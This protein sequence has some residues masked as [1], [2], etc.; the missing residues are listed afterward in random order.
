[1][2][3]P[4]Y[5]EDPSK[6]HVGCEIPRAYYVPYESCEAACRPREE[7]SR[8]RM[9]TGNWAFRFF[10]CFAGFSEKLLEEE[11]DLSDWDN[12]P[13]PSCWQLHGYDRAQYV[14]VNYP[15]PCDP[16][17]VPADNP[18]GLYIRDVEI[19]NDG[20]RRYLVL[21]GVDSCFYLFVNGRFVAY[22]Q[23]S[24]ATTEVEL[25]SF[26]HPGRNRL[27]ILVFKW[28]DGSYLEDQDKF[29]YSGIFREVYLKRSCLR[30]RSIC[31]GIVL[32]KYWP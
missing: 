15:F 13:V 21:E 14:N 32:V 5:H 28:C 1:M 17:F 22:S 11:S 12:L 3:I 27:A 4:H 20:Q 18:A 26:F 25:T 9:L 6:L 23:V 2:Q 29:R 10:E 8:V 31:V 19:P 24:H 16:P 30:G 7:S